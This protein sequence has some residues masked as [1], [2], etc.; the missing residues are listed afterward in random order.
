MII[1]GSRVRHK[2]TEIDKIKGV[3]QVFEIKNRQAL[4]GY[5]DFNRIGQGMELYNLSELIIE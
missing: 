1:K 4:C 3:M 2:N 5:A